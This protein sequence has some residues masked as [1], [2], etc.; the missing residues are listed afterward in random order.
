MTEFELATL[1]ADKAA[2]YV[3]MAQVA[4]TTVVGAGQIAI[5]WYGI[6]A[7]DRAGERRAAEQDQRHQEAMTA[8]RQEH[9]ETLCALEALIRQRDARTAALRGLMAETGSE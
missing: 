5:V 6:R 7:M 3:A 4:A 1:A 8:L 2:L 9:A